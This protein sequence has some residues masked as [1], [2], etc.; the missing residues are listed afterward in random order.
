VRI[1]A[2]ARDATAANILKKG[3][4]Q[5][6]FV[7]DLVSDGEKGLQ[8]AAEIDYDA[9]VVGSELSDVDSLARRLKESR[10]LVPTMFLG[11]RNGASKPVNALDPDAVNRLGKPFSPEELQVKLRGL[12]GTAPQRTDTPMGDFEIVHMLQTVARGGRHAR[13]TP[14]EYA[15]LEYLKNNASRPLPPELVA[16]K[17]TSLG[18]QGLTNVVSAY[19]KD[20]RAKVHH[21]LDL[22]PAPAPRTNG[23]LNGVPNGGGYM[24]GD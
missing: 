2:I 8:L 9:V 11:E 23:H 18:F 16:E 15:A 1:L 14:S 24:D 5:D 17:I 12:V 13:L 6:S 4:E 3:L 22:P 21:R 20:L 10:P 7:V 19:I